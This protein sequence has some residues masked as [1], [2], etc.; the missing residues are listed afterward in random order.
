MVA[1]KEITGVSQPPGMVQVGL[2]NARAGRAKMMRHLP[3]PSR[4]STCISVNA[5]VPSLSGLM[6]DS[7][8][9]ASRLLPGPCQGLTS[10]FPE[11]QQRQWVLS[12][13]ES[14]GGIS[15]VPSKSG[16]WVTVTL[17]LR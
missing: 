7:R 9:R 4:E 17:A 15:A 11:D 6:K 12:H 13:T 2:F 16:M 8:Y 1:I 5:S 10:L 14:T 3:S